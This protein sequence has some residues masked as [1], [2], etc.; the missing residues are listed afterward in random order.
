LPLERAELA[1][2]APS[3]MSQVAAI[4]SRACMSFI[5]RRFSTAAMP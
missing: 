4:V 1:I 5:T 3:A 2:W